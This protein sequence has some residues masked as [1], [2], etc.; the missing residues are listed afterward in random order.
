MALLILRYLLAIAALAGLA[1]AATAAP[2]PQASRDEAPAM[3]ADC[4]EMMAGREQ[5]RQKPCDGTFDCM[6]AMG[7]LT[8]VALPEPN[9]STSDPVPAVAT[10]YPLPTILLEGSITGPE[11]DPPTTFG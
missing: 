9:W 10:Y 2:L 11:P 4:M 5:P 6:V 7:C 1:G 8:F 3:S